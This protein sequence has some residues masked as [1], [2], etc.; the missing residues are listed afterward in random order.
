[1]SRIVARLGQEAVEPVGEFLSRCLDHD[2]ENAPS[3]QS[4]LGWFTDYG[5]VIKRDMDLGTGEIRVMTVH[6]AKGLESNIVFL[7]DTCAI[8]DRNKHPRLFFPSVEVN[9]VA[10]EVPLWRVRLDCDHSLIVKMRTEHHQRQLEEHGRLLYVAMTRAADYLYVCGA[11]TRDVS[12]DCW[13]SRIRSALM[14]IG[15]PVKDGEGRTLWRYERLAAEPPP[16]ETPSLPPPRAA[17]QP[18]PSWAGT[19]PQAE[20]KSPVWLTPSRPGALAVNRARA[21]EISS[22][23]AETGPGRF[24]RGVLLHRLLQSLPDVSPAEREGR[25]RAYLSHA[26]HDLTAA[27]REEIVATVM[28]LLEDS[29]FSGI[30]ALGSLAEIPLAAY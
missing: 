9:G 18:L 1:M 20:E 15:R 12:E 8:P 30:F 29:A 27:A 26:G 28:R 14:K 13:Y 17:P 22:P 16:A 3:L 23:L 21:T 6:G 2:L 19:L 11:S 24:R 7:P 5:A 25:A 4:F 10:A